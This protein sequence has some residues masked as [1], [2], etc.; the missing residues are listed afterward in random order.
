MPPRQLSLP[1]RA[2]LKPFRSFL[3]LKLSSA[4]NAATRTTEL[5]DALADLARDLRGATV[6]VRSA[7][8]TQGE[9][10]SAYAVYRRERRAAWTTHADFVD[11]EHHLLLVSG[12]KT[13]FAVFMSDASLREIMKTEMEEQA[14]SLEDFERIP[15][16]KLNAVLD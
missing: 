6:P 2:A 1:N 15:T 13:L 14:Q 12:Y 4:G 5:R 9:L 7:R 10:Y 8:S 3:F 11:V 16:N